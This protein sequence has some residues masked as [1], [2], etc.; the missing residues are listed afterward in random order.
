MNR[1]RCVSSLA[2]LLLLFAMGVGAS[3]AT[4]FEAKQFGAVGDGRTKDTAALQRAIDAA[5]KSGGTV[6]LAAGTFLSGSLVLKS[7]VTLQIDK[8]ATLLGSTEHAD[9]RKNR[10]MALVEAKGQRDIAIVGEGVIDGQGAALAADVLRLVQEKKIIDPLASNRPAEPNRPQLLELMDCQGVTVRGITLKNSSCWVQ[11]YLNCEDV[12]LDHVTVRST[13]YWN[14]DGLDLVDCRR[15][16]VTHCDIDCA[17]D[18]ICL[19]SGEGHACEDIVVEDCAVRSSASAFKLGTSS[20]GGFKHIRAHGLRIHDTFRSAIALESVDGA[21]MEDVEV[22][23]VQAKNTGAA[24]F[25]RL[26]NR[27]GVVGSVRDVRISDVTVEIPATAPDAGYPLAGPAVRAAHNLFPSSITG[28]PGHRVAGVSLK[29]ITIT[30]AGGGRREVAE[31]PLENLAAVPEQEDRYPEFSMFGEL[32]AWGFYVRHAE[33]ITFDNVAIRATAKD[34]R[35]AM[36]FDDV[37]N[38]QLNSVIMA[39][40]GDN[41]MIVLRGAERWKVNGTIPPAGTKEFIRNLDLVGGKNP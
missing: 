6:R 29:N 2:G 7:G 26:G 19:K 14:N 21:A 36:V 33:G 22:S 12:T 3:A 28:L 15:A 24:I 5:A 25:I 34:F 32:P 10:W 35:A 11:T 17:D 8:G 16:R 27:H 18:G 38:L 39:P 37:G 30:T 41:P 23:D 4:V 40:A 20:R 9:Y 31:V 1:L 13:A